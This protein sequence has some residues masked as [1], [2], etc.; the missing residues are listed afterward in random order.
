MNQVATQNYRILYPHMIIKSG[1][2]E[3]KG[4][5]MTMAHFKK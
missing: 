1:S 3:E 2:A 4:K 5:E